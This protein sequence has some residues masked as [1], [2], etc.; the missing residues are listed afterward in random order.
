[1]YEPFQLPVTYKGKDL[2]LPAQLIRF[3]YTH[4]FKISVNEI[5]VMFEPDE[6]GVYRAMI[7][8]ASG[9]KLHEDHQ[10]L[11]QQIARVLQDL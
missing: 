6:E 11:L 9:D 1:M 4:K 3:G 5:N 2:L 7:D 10:G 8:V